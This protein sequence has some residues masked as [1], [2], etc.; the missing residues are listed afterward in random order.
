[1]HKRFLD[2]SLHAGHR[3]CFPK[4]AANSGDQRVADWLHY[5]AE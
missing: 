2:G 3:V 1:M 4:L 5:F